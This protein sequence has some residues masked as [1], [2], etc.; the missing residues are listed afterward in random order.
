MAD[1]NLMDEIE[2]REAKARRV[3]GT[4]TIARGLWNGVNDQTKVIPTRCHS[5]CFPMGI[6]QLKIEVL[7]VTG[8]L[9]MGYSPQANILVV[10]IH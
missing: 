5:V 7:P 9:D 8:E 4:M 2:Q 1:S 3:A 10:R 6:G